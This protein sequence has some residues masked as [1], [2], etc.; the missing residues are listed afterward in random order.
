RPET[1]DLPL[2]VVLERRGLASGWS[3]PVLDLP[4]RHVD[5]DT[6][7]SAWSICVGPSG[8]HQ[9]QSIEGDIQRLRERLLVEVPELEQVEIILEKNG[10][11]APFP[12]GNDA[13]AATAEALPEG[14]NGQEERDELDDYMEMIALK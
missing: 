8:A 5:V 7:T 12:V 2:R 3:D 13:L 11:V 6:T 9:L 14:Q 4:V 1:D 10:H